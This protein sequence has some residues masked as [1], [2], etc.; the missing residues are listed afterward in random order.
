MTESPLAPAEASDQQVVRSTVPPNRMEG[1]TPNTA[2]TEVNVARKITKKLEAPACP[3]AS[4]G[5]ASRTAAKPDQSRVSGFANFGLNAHPIKYVGRKDTGA[6]NNVYKLTRA[7]AIQSSSSA[8]QRR[9]VEAVDM[10]EL[11]ELLIPANHLQ[12]YRERGSLPIDPRPKMPNYLKYDGAV[13]TNL[14]WRPIHNQ[15]ARIVRG[16]METPREDG[17]IN[18]YSTEQ[19]MLVEKL[20]K[21]AAVAEERSIQQLNDERELAELVEEFEKPLVDEKYFGLENYLQHSGLSEEG[22][23]IDRNEH[24]NHLD[25]QLSVAAP[26]VPIPVGRILRGRLDG[27]KEEANAGKK[28]HTHRAT[29]L[30]DK[31]QPDPDA[32]SSRPSIPKKAVNGADSPDNANA[33]I[34]NSTSEPALERA[35]TF[36]LIEN[37]SDAVVVGQPAPEKL[38]VRLRRLDTDGDETFTFQNISHGSID[39]S[40]KSHVLSINKWR[41]DIFR[42]RG[43][44]A[45]RV[46]VF[47]HPEE[48]AWLM[49]FHKKI[50]LVVEAGHMIKLPGPVPTMEFF[51]KLFVGKVLQDAEGDDLLPREPRDESSMKSKFQHVNSGFKNMRNVMRKL[52]EG[53]KGGVL[54]VPVITEEEFLLY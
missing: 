13:V 53:K 35:G 14:G 44:A 4:S 1:D 6:N 34:Q 37:N 49:L 5:D 24:D 18:K 8:P 32:S 45:K 9:V 10:D 12:T 39:W 52:L 7:S 27:N 28:K 30:S 19:D 21:H 20:R 51:N 31:L 40:D 33:V 25:A 36:E 29:V 3:A 41:Y 43:I 54:Y 46:N 23:L 38:Y 11:E 47:F 26:Q 42:R 2:A 17:I 48:E 15:N 50:K 16:P 22:R